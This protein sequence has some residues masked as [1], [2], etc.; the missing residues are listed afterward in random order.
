[1]KDHDVTWLYGPLQT[2][3]VKAFNLNLTPQQVD[4]REAILSLRKNL[5][6]RSGAYPRLCFNGLCPLRP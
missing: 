6:S 3:N 2:G 1:M 4:F 5:S